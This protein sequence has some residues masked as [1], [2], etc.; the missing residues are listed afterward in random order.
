[1]IP[2]ILLTVLGVYLACGLMFAV[3]FAFMGAKRMDPHAATGSWGFRVLIIPG[4][5]AFW[6]LL[7]RRWVGGVNAPPEQQDPHRTSATKTKTKST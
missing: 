5:M 1:M 3:P 4:A 2:T 7:L 6:P